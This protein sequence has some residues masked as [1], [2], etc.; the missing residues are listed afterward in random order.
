MPNRRYYSPEDIIK[1]AKK[2]IPGVDRIIEE[3]W[4]ELGLNEEMIKNAFGLVLLEFDRLATEKFRYYETKAL[5]KLAELWLESQGPNLKENLKAV[6]ESQDFINKL[7][8]MFVEFAYMVQRLEKDLGNMRKARG[9][10]TF[11]KV[12]CGLLNFIGISCEIPTGEYRERL[13]R[14]DIVI[15]NSVEALENPDKAVFI[16]CKRTLR[17]RWR[18]E[19]PAVGP[20]QR[21]YL[22]TLDEELSQEKAKEIRDLGLIVYVRDDLKQSRFGSKS[23][24]R[25]LSDLPKDISPY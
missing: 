21:V 3:T 7:A 14:I 15:P 19:V 20:N 16:T 6:L 9:G 12:I 11:E 4:E 24:V 23:W 13:K 10:K 17:E 5:K 1:E 18:Q 2:Q 8:S 25:K 22:L